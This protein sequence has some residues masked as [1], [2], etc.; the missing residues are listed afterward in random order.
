MLAQTWER[1]PVP[2]LLSTFNH[3]SLSVFFFFFASYLFHLDKVIKCKVCKNSPSGNIS[4]IVIGASSK[5][6]GDSNGPH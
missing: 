1:V 2:L 4:V 5:E 6:H 3:F